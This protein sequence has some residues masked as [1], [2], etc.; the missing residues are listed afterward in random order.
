MFLII[1]IIIALCYKYINIKMSY[2][3]FGVNGELNLCYLFMQE[4]KTCF[5]NKIY[6]QTNCKN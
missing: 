1:N 5:N 3:Y 6:P 4:L 2:P